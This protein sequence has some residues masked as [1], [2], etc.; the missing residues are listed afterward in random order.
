M[1]RLDSLFPLV[2]TLASSFVQ[3]ALLL[4]FS[5]LLIFFSVV[6]VSLSKQKVCHKGDLNQLP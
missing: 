4:P 2:S 6:V 1:T 5:L 3:S